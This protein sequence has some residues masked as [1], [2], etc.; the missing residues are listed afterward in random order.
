MWSVNSS[1]RESH[2]ITTVLSTYL[3]HN[4]ISKRN[5]WMAVSSNYSMKRF[6]T[7][8]LTGEKVVLHVLMTEVASTM[9]KIKEKSKMMK[10]FH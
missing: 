9:L 7:V 3:R 6:A 2:M 4:L 1:N 10:C 5:V 8:R